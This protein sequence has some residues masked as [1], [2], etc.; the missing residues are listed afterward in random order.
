MATKQMKRVKKAKRTTMTIFNEEAYE[1]PAL[2]IPRGLGRISHNELTSIVNK[3]GLGEIYK[4]IIKVKAGKNTD[5]QRPLNSKKTKRGC[6]G[7]C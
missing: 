1:H 6:K 5:D 7:A 3:T 2:C 4:I